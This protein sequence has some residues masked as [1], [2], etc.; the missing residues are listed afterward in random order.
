MAGVSAVSL[1]APPGP[2]PH[3]HLIAQPDVHTVVVD[4]VTVVGLEQGVDDQHRDALQDEGGEEVHMDVVPRAVQFA[5]EVG[6][7]GQC[8]HPA[9]GT[10]PA[11]ST[12][13]AYPHLLP[14]PPARVAMPM[15]LPEAQQQGQGE[16]QCAQRHRV[17][18]CVHHLEAAVGLGKLLL[19]QAGVGKDGGGSGGEQGAREGSPHRCPP[20]PTCAARSSA[21]CLHCVAS[22]RDCPLGPV[23]H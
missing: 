11:S 19:V 8:P 13:L 22:R 17:P 23:T 15:P 2:Q 16:Q 7:C 12:A 4:L 1:P 3:T 20:L 9:T 21:S 5:A 18:H 10:A 6:S 14:Q